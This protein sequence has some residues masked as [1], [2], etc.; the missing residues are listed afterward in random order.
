LSERNAWAASPGYRWTLPYQNLQIFRGTIAISAYCRKQPFADARHDAGRAREVRSAGCSA[1]WFDL[2]GEGL[3]DYLPIPH[4]KCVGTKFIRIGRC[5]GG[6]QNIA[7][8][9]LSR[10]VL[11]RERGT[12]LC[13][14]RNEGLKERL[15]R[16][17]TS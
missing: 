9:A 11:H 8:I 16:G 17:R 7:V 5:V 3:R 13:K 6:P 1:L 14:L 15:D 4:N 12:R 10:S 2:S